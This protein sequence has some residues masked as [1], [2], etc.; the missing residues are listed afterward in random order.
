MRNATLITAGL[1]TVA[2]GVLGGMAADPVPRVPAE[3]DWRARYRMMAAVGQA[4]LPEDNFTTASAA[5][6][7]SWPY[8][9]PGLSR[10]RSFVSEV[11]LLPEVSE[12]L[13][14]ERALPGELPP[15]PW[16]RELPAPDGRAAVADALARTGGIA[17]APVAA[18]AAVAQAA[19]AEAV[20]PLSETTGETAP[21]RGEGP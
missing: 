3:A 6:E 11:R 5:S 17:Q 1:A 9:M 4:N 10:V 19:A 15:D 21:M 14:L 7:P 16:V 8:V 18:V 20:Q 2:I 12:N 13:P